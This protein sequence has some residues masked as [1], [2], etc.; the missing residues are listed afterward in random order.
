MLLPLNYKALYTLSKRKYNL[1]INM[2]LLSSIIL[3]FSIKIVGL[4]FK[5]IN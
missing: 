4:S 5:D 1:G 3:V 2:Y